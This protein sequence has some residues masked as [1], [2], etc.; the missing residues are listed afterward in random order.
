VVC[1]INILE[2]PQL[3]NPVLIEG[4][5]GIGCVA[6]ISALHLIKELKQKVRRNSFCQLSR[7]ADLLKTVNPA[8]H[9]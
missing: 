9:K 4:L 3:N 2:K 5:P 6:N 1:S 7:L 8:F